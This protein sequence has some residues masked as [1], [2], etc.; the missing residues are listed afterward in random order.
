M[1]FA[2]ASVR[3]PS[4]PIGVRSGWNE[5]RKAGATRTEREGLLEKEHLPLK[6]DVDKYFEENKPYAGLG[7]TSLH[8][9]VT[10]VVARGV[11]II[12]QV[13]STILL[14]RLLS[15]DDFGL[16]AMVLA[17]AGLAPM[18]IDL[19]TSEASTQKTRISEVEVS[20]LFWLNVAI[21]IVLTAVFAGGSGLIAAF[22]GEPAL[23]G[24]ALVSSLTFMTA[25]VSTQH[26]AL[27]RRAMQF[28]HIA[29]IDIS[30]N[31]VGSIV[32][33]AMAFTGWGYWSL[34][35]KPIVTS[36][37]AVVG[38]WISCPWVPGRPRLTPEVKELV[39]FGMGVTGFTITDY[40]ARSDDRLALG[41]VYG[42][43]PLGYVPNAFLVYSNVLNILTEPLHNIASSSLSKL[44]DDLGELRRSWASA[45]SLTSF[46]S[47]AVFATLAVT[48]Q[49]F[50]VLLLGQRWAPAGPLL[51]VFA[52]R[53]IANSVERTLG[54]LHVVAGRPDRWVQWGIFSAGCHLLALIIGL[55]YGAM[56]VAV[57]YTV[58]IF[59]LFVP[60]LVYG[61]SPIGIGVRDVLSATAA[62]MGSAL[63]ATTIALTIQRVFLSEVPELLRLIV[64]IPMCA[65]TYL[66]IVLGVFRI[67]EP[68]KLASTL[69][70]D[71]KFSWP[72]AKTRRS[73]MEI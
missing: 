45:L 14:A 31:V 52:V 59:C 72:K 36:G 13:A 66:L 15:P 49:D 27:M 25:A 8:S 48:G 50:V 61:G 58:A 32:G 46:V 33:I 53:G 30:S 6:R 4:I 35:A 28:R 12:V 64:S 16:V 22:F 62:Q 51:C 24:I 18:L 19:G 21:G 9:G 41:Y 38:V 47:A 63:I 10:F 67:T 44:R 56:G 57:A 2:G 42:P 11:N 37:L 3:A 26:Y 7:R 40:L 23:S 60:A 69:L 68:L 39:G 71:Y 43:G 29:I 54:W 55:P 73:A 65:V 17:L 20:T 34:V 1:Q 5:R 70:H